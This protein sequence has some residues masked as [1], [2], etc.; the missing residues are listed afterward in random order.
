[1][2][3]V[4]VVALARSITADASAFAVMTRYA[5]RLPTENLFLE[6]PIYLVAPNAYAGDVAAKPTWPLA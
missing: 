5:L 1:M 3:Q 2:K 6:A 4:S